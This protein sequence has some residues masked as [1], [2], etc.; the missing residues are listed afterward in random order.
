MY[1][2]L[3]LVPFLLLGGV[4]A[5]PKQPCL[6][7]TP[8]SCALVA[9]QT[10]L[11][12]E[13]PKDVC[14][15][16]MRTTV[17]P[18]T[19]YATVT[20]TAF[21]TVEGTD[22]LTKSIFD[23]A[24]Q[25]DS[26]SVT[27][28]ET[29]LTTVTD[30]ATK[31]NSV[32]VTIT[33]TATLT[34]T[35][36]QTTT[37]FTTTTLGLPNPPKQIKQGSCVDNPS[38]RRAIAAGRR[39]VPVPVKADVSVSASVSAVGASVPA[40]AAGVCLDGNAY[41]SACRC[42]G[43][44]PTTV[45]APV[46]SATLTVT[47]GAQVTESTLLD[48]TVS[49]TTTATQI[50]TILVTE[51]V[52]LTIT[53]SSTSTVDQTE[54]FTTVATTTTGVLETT[55]T[56]VTTTVTPP[57]PSQGFLRVQGSRFDGQYAHIDFTA[58]NNANHQVITFVEQAQASF[59]F[60]TETGDISQAGYE[61]VSPTSPT[62]AHAASLFFEPPYVTNAQGSGLVRLACAVAPG[63]GLV[64]CTRPGGPG[65]PVVFQQCDSEAAGYYGDGV[66]ISDLEELN[67]CSRFDFVLEGQS[68]T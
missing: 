12:A 17:T 48:A 21:Q 63:T 43:V 62:S 26:T 65:G 24:T 15:A 61:A 33:E 27:T 32:A 44:R 56:T 5:K 20:A 1:K 28:S 14:S 66:V 51:M 53:V 50:Q 35:A 40:Y 59:V 19:S 16:F 13:N 36:T 31:T 22:I 54:S 7:C 47:E 9:L 57:V 23:T 42:A 4:Q 34:T 46:P 39:N 45:T 52:S 37:C 2:A 8:D 38:L 58:P 60:L 30:V 29:S 64:A 6:K 41:S 11:A 3:A 18:L 25:T 68:F 49:L 55:A 10:G 67:G